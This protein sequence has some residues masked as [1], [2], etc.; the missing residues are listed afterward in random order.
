MNRAGHETSTAA[1]GQPGIELALKI[2]FDLIIT[3][4]IMPEKEG[5]ETIMELRQEHPEIPIVAMSGGGHMSSSDILGMARSFGAIAT[6]HKPFSGQL[7]L[8]TIE[9]I[10]GSNSDFLEEK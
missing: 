7:L 8:E 9:N 10:M 6:L 5:L 2:R 3:D 4:I 1:D